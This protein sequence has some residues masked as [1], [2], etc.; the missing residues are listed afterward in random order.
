M[1]LSLVVIIVT[2]AAVC[3]GIVFTVRAFKASATPATS[4]DRGGNNT[5]SRQGIG[6]HDRATTE[7]LKRY[8]EGKE[9]AICKRPIPPVR[10][11]LKPGLVNPATHEAYS[12]DAIP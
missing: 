11:G 1:D 9:C 10:T 7:L 6:P 5:E 4:P 8:F 2:T 3:A 12:W